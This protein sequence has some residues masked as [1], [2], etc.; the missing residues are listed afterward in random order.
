MRHIYRASRMPNGGRPID[1]IAWIFDC[2]ACQYEYCYDTREA[3]VTGAT[4]HCRCA[5]GDAHAEVLVDLLAD[6]SPLFA[7]WIGTP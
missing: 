3:A 7:E 6:S 2:P 5:G 1:G 4:L